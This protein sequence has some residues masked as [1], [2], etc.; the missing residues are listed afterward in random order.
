[1]IFISGDSW[2]IGTVSAGVLIVVG[3]IALLVT[4]RRGW[5]AWPLLLISV[6]L[7]PA[8]GYGAT[9]VA[10]HYIDLKYGLAGGFVVHINILVLIALVP[11]IVGASVGL[12]SRRR[13]ADRS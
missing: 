7:V 8:L 4:R 12:A 1:M 6:L 9:M 11:A 13:T 3:A 10:L 5:K 2:L